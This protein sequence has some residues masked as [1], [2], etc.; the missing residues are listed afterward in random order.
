MTGAPG[1]RVTRQTPIFLPLTVWFLLISTNLFEI[2]TS[3]QCIMATGE[4]WFAVQSMPMMMPS[5]TFTPG[6]TPSVVIVGCAFCACMSAS[7]HPQ[8]D[9]CLKGSTH[10]QH[11][12]PC[13]R[14]TRS[15]S[16]QAA[17]PEAAARNVRRSIQLKARAQALAQE[18]V[19][20]RAWWA[21]AASSSKQLLAPRI[22]ERV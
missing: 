22:T 17:N 13:E 15:T 20:V 5:I 18:E 9:D 1:A 10:P 6:A 11:A 3:I 12:S 16:L 2:V 21:G 14:I 4:G 7:C 19:Q 8:G